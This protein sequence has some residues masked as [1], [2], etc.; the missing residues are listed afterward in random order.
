MKLVDLFF[1][2][3]RFGGIQSGF[4]ISSRVLKFLECYS[5]SAERLVGRGS[6]VL[7]G[8]WWSEVL[9]DRN[10]LHNTQI[11]SPSFLVLRL[12]FCGLFGDL[13]EV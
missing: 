8:R 10:T 1:Y 5:S 4:E 11:I 6:L 7:T 9:V 3:A 13:W 2:I 12:K